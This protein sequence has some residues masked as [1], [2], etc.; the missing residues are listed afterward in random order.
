MFHPGGIHGLNPYLEEAACKNSVSQKTAKKS[1]RPL[2]EV[3]QSNPDVETK[4]LSS[5]SGVHHLQPCTVETLRRNTA[6]PKVPHSIPEIETELL[7]S[8]VNRPKQVFQPK[9][10]S[11]ASLR[12]SVPVTHQLLA[13]PNQDPK[14]NSSQGCDR[15]IEQVSSTTK[16]MMSSQKRNDMVSQF[17]LCYFLNT[18]NINNKVQKF[19]DGVVDGIL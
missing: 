16:V 9:R 3:P 5:P 4:L 8:P 11:S 10:P 13:S 1:G 12:T 2:P 17:D 15:C 18:N 14:Y 19:I 7:S 6:L